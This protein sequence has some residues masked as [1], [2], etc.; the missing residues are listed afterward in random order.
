V[1]SAE[2]ITVGTELLLGQL[3][4]SN[5]AEIAVALADAG[6]D[7]H[8]ETSVGDNRE[9]VT[10]AVR[11]ALS[12]ADCAICA[13][14][15]GPTVDDLTRDGIAAALERPL[16]LDQAA[17]TELR[18]RFASFGRRMAENN[19]QQAMLPR[20]AIVMENP[21]GTA[22]GFIVDHG[23]KIVAAMP[24]VPRELR[25][26]L[27]ERLIPWLV[28]R[29]QIRSTL[30]TR[31]LKTI[32]VGESDLDQRIADLFRDSVNPSIAVLAHVG[33]VDVK[34]TAKADT[35][36]A[37]VALL[38]ALEPQ[39]RERLGD[40]IFAVDRGS[41][42]EVA[43]ECLRRRGWTIATAESCTGGLASAMITSVAGA[44]DY[45]RG[46]VIAYGDE[47]KI[48]A[49][50]VAPDLL[51]RYGAVSEEVAAALALGAQA[52]FHA[53]LAL[54]ITGIAGPGGGSAEK[55][56]GLVYVALAGPE[57]KMDVR[58]LQ[59]P[60]DR[61]AIQRRAALAALTLL[62]KATR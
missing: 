50:D 41:I 39:L 54:S 48:A 15:L 55:P 60:G 52:A 38:D 49:L 1:A 23:G 2:I 45:F 11:I 32:G 59:L 58:R 42:E 3:V 5:T 56:V 26:M 51:D 27:K 57:A 30:V 8:Y 10:E 28:E 29:F 61:E 13:G 43:G 21:L 31:V 53:T 22:P 47:A 35:R 40:V 14:G 62:W 7:V 34:M 24:G 33:T 25:L 6:I 19:V 12:R 37:A 16:E 17:L 44:S 46:G 4:D 36:A 18:A 9:R 20:G